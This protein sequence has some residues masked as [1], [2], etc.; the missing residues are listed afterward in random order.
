MNRRAAAISG[1][2]LVLAAG[3]DAVLGEGTFPGYAAVIGLGGTVAI[4]YGSKALGSLV[5]RSEGHDVVA[6]PDDVQ[7]ELLDDD[8]PDAGRAGGRHG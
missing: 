5:N 1:G 8:H 3:L 4:T 2:A 7:P 6:A